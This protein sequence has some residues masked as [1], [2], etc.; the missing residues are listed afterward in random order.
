MRSLVILTVF[1]ALLAM[2]SLAHAA[3]HT[4]GAIGAI[5][6]TTRTLTLDNGT[7]FTLAEGVD[8]TS[9]KVGDKVKVIYKTVDG[10]NTAKTVKEIE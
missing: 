4:K 6:Q 10:V 9:L 5:D 8:Q 7:V 1:V 2:G 3:Q